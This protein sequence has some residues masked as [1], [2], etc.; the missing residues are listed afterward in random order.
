M[1]MN[2][3]YFYI[4]TLYLPLEVHIKIHKTIF[5]LL[6]ELQLLTHIA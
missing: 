5:T 1:Y 4:E 6:D 2:F 3:L